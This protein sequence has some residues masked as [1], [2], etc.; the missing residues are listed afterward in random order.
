MK[1]FWFGIRGTKK[2]G[3]AEFFSKLA[4][5][6]ENRH[7]QTGVITCI[8]AWLVYWLAITTHTRSSGIVR[9]G[10][11]CMVAFSF[12]EVKHSERD[13]ESGHGWIT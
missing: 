8:S 5:G 9:F 11:G 13:G 7:G 3:C 6:R 10:F 2:G 1:R 12:S 4:L